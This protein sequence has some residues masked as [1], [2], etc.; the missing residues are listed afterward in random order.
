MTPATGPD[1]L[2]HEQRDERF[3]DCMRRLD[4]SLARTRARWAAV[5]DVRLIQGEQ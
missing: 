1:G 5:R 4:E 2:T 3:A